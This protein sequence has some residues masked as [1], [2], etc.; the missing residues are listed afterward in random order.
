MELDP[1]YIELY[2]YRHIVQVIS[3]IDFLFSTLYFITFI[4]PYMVIASMI[5]LFGYY[6]AKL[7]NN[8]MLTIYGVY[9]I[10]ST[11]T[12]ILITFE[13][14]KNNVKLLYIIFSVISVFYKVYFTYIIFY[15]MK[16]IKNNQLLILDI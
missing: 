13:L 3:F 14:F 1:Q 9:S 10:M 7:F 5:S 12:Q 8:E 11:V 2:R 16:L 4:S 6:G 15:L